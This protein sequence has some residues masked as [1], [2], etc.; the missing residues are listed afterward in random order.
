MNYTYKGSLRPHRGS[1]S[2]KLDT[3]A[4][5]GPK[6]WSPLEPFPES[7]KIALHVLETPARERH[8]SFSFEKHNG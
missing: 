8:D 1:R 6:S 7:F 4:L 5:N 3:E 2:L